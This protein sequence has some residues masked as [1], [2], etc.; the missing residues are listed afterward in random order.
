VIKLSKLP[1]ENS[2]L[3]HQ[4]NK[5]L[6]AK[7]TADIA[8]HAAD[9]DAHHTVYA[10]TYAYDHLQITPR[11]ESDFSNGFIQNDAQLDWLAAPFFVHANVD[12]S[13]NLDFYFVWK[14]TSADASITGKKYVGTRKTDGTEDYSWDV[15]N[16][17]A[18]N[19]DSTTADRIKIWQYT[20]AAANFSASDIVRVGWYLNEAARAVYFT[21]AYVRYTIA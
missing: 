8:T 15:E 11:Y 9:D 13:A 2:A 19:F 1:G 5:A 20:L 12:A 17:T 3:I 18:E 6:N 16:G 14:C 4:I 10:P 7:I 21:A